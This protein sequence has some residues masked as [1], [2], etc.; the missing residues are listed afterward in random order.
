[1]K[2]LL[3]PF[4]LAPLMAQL[5]ATP[6]PPKLTPLDEL[7]IP[8]AEETYANADRAQAASLNGNALFPAKDTAGDIEKVRKEAEANR[9]NAELW[10]AL[11]KVQDNYMRYM[12]SVESYSY[13][14]R[15]FPKDVRFLQ[16]RGRRYLAL[17]K[18]D[19]AVADL[20][21]AYAVASKTYNVSYYLGIAYYMNDQHEKAAA[22]L[23]ACESQ[24]TKP[25]GGNE[26]F[27]GMRGC[28]SLR[29]DLD[30]RAAMIYWRYLALRRAGK[31][32]EAKKYLDEASP[33]WQLKDGKPFW[34]A[35][36]YF[37]GV[38]ELN[39]VLAGANEGGSAFLTRSS[40]AAVYLFTEGERKQACGIWQRNAMDTNW[41][42]LGVILA[43]VEY[44]KNSATACALYGSQIPQMKQ[45]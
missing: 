34:E 15:Q 17:R 36:M 22:V 29:E 37:K 4:L 13:G 43:E 19:L 20:E 5:P 16:M 45:P 33:L 32:A 39:E 44:Y 9:D 35:L 6:Q 7:K 2:V 26:N 23:G 25:S 41:D 8:K 10:L 14:V 3:I 28:D 40:A 27:H 38:K 12:D 11:G 42:R 18:F 24:M 30:T 21:K 31:M 1:M